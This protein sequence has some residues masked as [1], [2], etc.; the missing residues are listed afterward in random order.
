M[1]AIE[2]VLVHAGGR[3]ESPRP[4]PRQAPD[5]ETRERAV[6]MKTS[7][8]AGAHGRRVLPCAAAVFAMLLMSGPASAGMILPTDVR[9]QLLDH[10]DGNA[11][12]PTYGLRLD[13]LINVTPG[14]DRFTFSFEHPQALMQMMLTEV[15]AGEFSIHIWGT[16]FGG[17]VVNNEYD[18]LLSGLVEI[19][20]TYMLAHLVD[21]DDDLIV[22]TPSFMN[23]GSIMFN[24]STIDLFDRANS[25]GFSFRLGNEDDDQGHRGFDGISGWGWLDHG[26]AGTYVAASDW[27]FTVVPTPGP[28]ALLA[29]AAALFARARRRRR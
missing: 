26:K 25:E 19:D 17:L 14:H 12:P 7:V 9:L 15:G 5:T 27:L 29:I 23:T 6:E 4:G 2:G 22:T 18:P 16:A 8:R 3:E 1:L 21:G 13:E 11:A 10:P 28:T 20:F 24:G